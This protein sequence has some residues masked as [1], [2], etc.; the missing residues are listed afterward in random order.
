[1]SEI[2]KISSEVIGT[3][4]VNSVNA[5]ELY[6]VLEIKKQFADWI[7]AQI[8]SLELEINID[9]IVFTES[10]KAGNGTVNRKE[11]ILTT[12]TAQHIALAS[13]TAKG[14]E[15]RK[16]FI[17]VEREFKR[18]MQNPNIHELSGRVGGLTK[19]NNDLRR[20]LDKWKKKSKRRFENLED[21]VDE[22]KS[23]TI[24]ITNKNYDEKMD[25]LFKQSEQ[26]MNVK[27][28]FTRCT[29]IETL[30]KHNRFYRDYIDILKSDGNTLQKWATTEI[31]KLKTE[32]NNSELELYHLKY[33]F[34]KNLK[35]IAD[36]QN[37]AKII[38]DFDV[39]E[40]MKFTII[41]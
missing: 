22:L 15:V 18:L 17:Q 21:D 39:K 3:E 1:M 6:Q 4:K 29:L 19:S 25:I 2:I 26:L 36:L 32:R 9:Y 30:Q 20:E 37:L 16:Y 7:N 23:K 34:E 14:R 11:Y 28:E 13:R 38:V 35:K 33:R 8:S 24:Y 10:V 41:D 31:D 27:G 40:Q 12:D 5:R